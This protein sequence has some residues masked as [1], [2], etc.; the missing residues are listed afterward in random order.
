MTTAALR[1]VYSQMNWPIEG[2]VYA[3]YIKNI[4][5]V[6]FSPSSSLGDGDKMVI[7][8]SLNVGFTKCFS[9]S[10]MIMIYLF[11]PRLRNIS[12]SKYINMFDTVFTVNVNLLSH[13]YNTLQCAP[14]P[15]TQLEGGIT[16]RC[17]L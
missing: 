11:L 16:P 7:S 15:V 12:G 13:P 6:Q 4:T 1:R 14:P 8:F 17:S 2:N 9:S 10:V 3:C 5:D